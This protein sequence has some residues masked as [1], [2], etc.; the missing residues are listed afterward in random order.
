ML[1]WKI[2]TYLVTTE[3]MQAGK[4]YFRIVIAT[5]KE[6]EWIGIGERYEEPWTA[7]L[8]FYLKK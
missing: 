7:Y 5:V 3:T 2:K 4:L 1:W 8:I 6:G